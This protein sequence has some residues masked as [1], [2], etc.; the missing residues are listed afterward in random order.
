MLRSSSSII[1][2]VLVIESLV[3]FID[4]IDRETFS[5]FWNFGIFVTFRNFGTDEVHYDFKFTKVS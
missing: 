3:C 2:T 5:K 1:S 4:H